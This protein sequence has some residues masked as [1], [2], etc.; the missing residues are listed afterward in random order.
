M[1]ERADSNRRHTDFQSDALPAELH[2]LIGIANMQGLFLF[3]KQI[4]QKNNKTLNNRYYITDN[5]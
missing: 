3:S 4:Q 2:S 5:Q 1:W